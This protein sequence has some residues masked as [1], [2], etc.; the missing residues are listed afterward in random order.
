MMVVDSTGA[1]S[2]SITLFG[3]P[4]ILTPNSGDPRSDPFSLEHVT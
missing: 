2:N 3:F 4:G 1:I